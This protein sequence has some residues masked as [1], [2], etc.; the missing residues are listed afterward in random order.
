M[1]N[2]YFCGRGV[3]VW[4]FYGRCRFGVEFWRRGDFLGRYKC[5]IDGIE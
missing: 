3:G 4:G 5:Y 2:G 1:R